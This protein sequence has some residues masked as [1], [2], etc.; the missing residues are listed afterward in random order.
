M[1]LGPM[2]SI[3]RARRWITTAHPDD[4]VERRQAILLESI[5]VALV[6]VIAVSTAVALVVPG[7]GNPGQTVRSFLPLEALFLIPLWMLRIGHF[8]LAA[9]A[10]VAVFEVIVVIAV[11]ATGPG[12]PGTGVAFAIPMTI[13]ALVLRRPGL[14]A[15]TAIAIGT[16]L[17]YEA[18]PGTTRS[19]P[20]P[21]SACQSAWASWVSSSIGSVSA[22]GRLWRARSGIAWSSRRPATR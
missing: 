15:T 4:V 16:I 2:D 6:L 9:T 13:A 11:L 1:K 3:D 7:F 5:L 18:A 10:T 19:R 8:P 17:V 21:S 22:S 14:I 20:R 12:S